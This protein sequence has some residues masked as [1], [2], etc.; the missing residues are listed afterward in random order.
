MKM[1]RVD[2]ED[3]SEANVNKESRETRLLQSILP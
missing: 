2:L 1:E 3:K